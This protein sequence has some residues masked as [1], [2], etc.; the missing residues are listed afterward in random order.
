[1]SDIDWPVVVSVA[2]ATSVATVVGVAVTAAVRWAGQFR[3]EVWE[4]LRKRKPMVKGGPFDPGSRVRLV[5]PLGSKYQARIGEHGEVRQVV[6]VRRSVVASASRPD[7][8]VSDCL[9]VFDSD[10]EQAW[11]YSHELQPA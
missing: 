9:V 3:K 5:Q 6:P 11:F 4:E 8:E 7:V 10:G 1:M 2:S